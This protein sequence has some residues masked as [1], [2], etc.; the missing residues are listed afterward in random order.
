MKKMVRTATLVTVALS[1]F[2]CGGAPPPST[3]G[4]KRVEIPIAQK[5]QVAK[6]P[7][8]ES[9]PPSSAAKASP[10]PKVTRSTLANGLRIAIVEEHALP[11]VQLR[12]L[13][14]AGTGYGPPGAAEIT[15]Q[16]LKDGG[17][18]AMTSAT[19]LR[20]VETLGADLGIGVDLDGTTLSLAVVKDHATE[21]LHLL[22]EVA[23]SPRFDLEELR[24]FKSRATDE[25]ED[26]ARS[27]GTWMATRVI[28][29]QLFAE[30]NPYAT[31][32][33]VPSEIAR[34]TATIVHDF[35]R[36]F[37]VP[38][39][40][41]VVI[42]GDIDAAA[43][44]SLVEKTFGTWT[45]GEAPVITVAETTPPANRRVFIADRPKSAQS[46]VF[47]AMLAPP[48]QSKDWPAVRVANQILGGGVSGRLFSDVREQRSLAYSAYARI[49][50][51]AH[52]QEPVVAYAGTQTN[53]TGLATAGL[54]ENLEKIVHEPVTDRETAI[55]TR[56]LSDIFAIRMETIG[57]IADLIVQQDELGLPDGYWDA[58]RAQVRD[59]DA[60]QAS[61]GARTLFHP[62]HALV[63]VAGDA[64]V[65]G[66]TLARFGDVTV[67]DPEH[68]FQTL[69]TIPMN[70]N[71]PLEI[72]TPTVTSP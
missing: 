36:R 12:I 68:E 50:E 8:R 67:L 3:V 38:K 17:T 39:N 34:V 40:T 55:A 19:L 25:A 14:H 13:V 11:I 22:G 64:D 54:L 46:D 62:D 71:A 20:K 60:A 27:S 45:G 42:T 37:Y 70:A 52:G 29:R 21:A 2:G 18:K 58:Y 32:D 53:K 5:G 56:Y 44:T 9:P 51:V 24:K 57:S 16:M 48:R 23:T 43:A 41:E 1:I 65:I 66:P 7:A 61:A 47:V 26:K 72:T 33:L 35:H 4:P 49:L 63:I 69:R 31:F 30:S 6:E 10:F 15:A 28:F 59:I